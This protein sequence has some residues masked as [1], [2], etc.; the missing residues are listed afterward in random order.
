MCEFFERFL[1]HHKGEHGGKPFLLEQ[2]EKAFLG[3]LFGWQMG[4][5]RRF[6]EAFLFVARKNG[7]TQLA[8]GIALYLL[9]ADGEPG[10]EI[11]TAAAERDQGRLIFDA[12]KR[13]VQQSE[14]LSSMAEVYQHAIYVPETGSSLKSLTAEASSKHGYNPHGILVDELHAHKSR[15]L[16]E[17]LQ[18]G[19]GSRK[20]PLTV[21]LTTAGFDQH[22]ICGEKYDYAK[23]VA[24]GIIQDPHFLPAIYESDKDDDWTSIATWKKANPNLGITIK[25]DYLVRECQRARETPGYENTFRRLHLNQW[26]E[27]ETRWLSMEVWDEG[28]AELPNLDGEPCWGG[29]DLSATTDLTALVLAFPLEGYVYAKA[30]AWCPQESMFRRERRDRVPYSAWARSGDIE[31]TEGNGV[32]YEVIRKRINELGERYNIQE[33]GVDRWNAEQLIG[34][35]MGDGF[36][37]KAFGQGFKDMS[38]PSKELERLTLERKLVH[39]GHPVLRWCASNVTIETDAAGNIKPSKKR[40]IERIDAIVA[41]VMAI[42]VSSVAVDVKSFYEDHALEV[43]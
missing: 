14:K 18:T 31:P 39:G 23:K 6:S 34:Q 26:T 11:Y 32:D 16:V 1:V 37:V 41:L 19:T 28:Q 24:G 30:Y 25:E 35:L 21:H 15:D 38:A 17:T 7:K 43:I 13:M 40:S 22:S 33:I 4:G 29:L 2:W 9:L 12:A 5:K 27:Q 20:Q 36:E 3:H 42:G 10:A 8:A